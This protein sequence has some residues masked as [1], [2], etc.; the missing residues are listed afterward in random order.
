[1]ILD[2]EYWQNRYQ[3]HTDNWDIGEV[4][5]PLKAYFDQITDKNIKILVA[6]GGDSHETSYLYNSGFKNVFLLDW[7]NNALDKFL[8]KNP[9]FPEN[10]TICGDFFEL[11][12]DFNHTFDLIIEQTFFCAISQ[13]KRPE[14][15]KKMHQLLKPNGKL[16][17]VL[18]DDFA[19]RTEP[20]FGGTQ[21]EYKPYFEPYFDFKYFEKC[22]NSIAPRA[23]REL[24]ILLQKLNFG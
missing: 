19:E 21:N 17:G 22:Y 10:Q 15:A 11:D 12:E 16:V 9:D 13:K 14:Y 7:A 3:N 18:F 2:A 1:M 24:F 23:N 4:S 20:P 8:I 5:A 6:G